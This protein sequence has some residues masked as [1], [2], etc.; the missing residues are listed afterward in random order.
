MNPPVARRLGVVLHDE[1]VGAVPVATEDRRRQRG[2][3]GGVAGLTLGLREL[4]VHLV[5]GVAT[6]GAR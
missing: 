3:G 1:Q 5:D 4:S 6:G 2:G